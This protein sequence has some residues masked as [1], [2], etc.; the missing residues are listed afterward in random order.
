MEKKIAIVEVAS[1][2]EKETYLKAEKMIKDI[3]LLKITS[4]VKFNPSSIEEKA[5]KFFEIF[6]SQEFDYIW[7]V[8]GGFGSIKL[9]PYLNKLFRNLGQ[10]LKPSL[11]IGYSDI[12][13]LHTYLYTK[14]N[15]P[16]I[17]GPNFINLVDLKKNCFINL[18]N[19]LTCKTRKITLEGIPFKQGEAKGTV[20][21]GNLATLCSLCGT[22]Y[23]PKLKEVILVLEEIN[24]KPY[25][26][27]RSLLQLIYF[28]GK[29][30]KGIAFGNLGIEEEKEML[31]SLSSFLPKGIPI[32]YNFPV[33]HISNSQF[34]LIGVKGRLEVDKEKA[35][36]VQHIH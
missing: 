25:R 7:A 32:G 18:L 21:G 10:N 9:F 4:F 23:F 14:L 15:V 17:H 34:F 16:G 28:L 2:P 30:L 8:R 33:G 1:T 13:A 26:I 19:F 36:L 5:K 29:K 22:R 31:K 27:E 3:P 24:E 20:L 12:T 11:L 35:L 6:S